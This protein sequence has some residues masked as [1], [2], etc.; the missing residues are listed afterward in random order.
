MRVDL[1][2]TESASAEPAPSIFGRDYDEAQ[3]IL[4]AAGN[5]ELAVLSPAHV[6]AITIAGERVK[7]AS[8]MSGF[9]K[10]NLQ[11]FHVIDN[12]GIWGNLLSKCKDL[13]QAKSSHYFLSNLFID[14]VVPL[15]ITFRRIML[16]H[17][18][19]VNVEKLL[20]KIVSEYCKGNVSDITAW[21]K[22]VM[23]LLFIFV[24]NF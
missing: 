21:S 5:P 17:D 10:L 15:G 1:S 9:A 13:R 18:T 22:E 20:I 16:L 23:S 24:F 8:N 11:Q 14:G 19:I 12:L 4:K 2:S 6:F 3:E 7:T